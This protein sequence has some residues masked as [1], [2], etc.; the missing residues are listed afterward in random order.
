MLLL[1]NTLFGAVESLWHFNIKVLGQTRLDGL[2]RD[3]G[4]RV[5]KLTCGEPWS[6]RAHMLNYCLIN[7]ISGFPRLKSLHIHHDVTNA[8]MQTFPHTVCHLSLSECYFDDHGLQ[9]LPRANLQSLS[10]C[11]CPNVTDAGL[12]HFENLCHLR[13]NY[14]DQVQALFLPP[15]LKSVFLHACPRVMTIPAL[16]ELRTL[17]VQYCH[18]FQGSAVTFLPNLR[19][20]QVR[21]CQLVQDTPRI[22]QEHL[23]RGRVLVDKFHPRSRHQLRYASYRFHV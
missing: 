12:S 5:L 10:L 2:A 17:S 1:V 7:D 14:I 3:Y 19:V 22:A 16:P 21:H 20:L 11:E 8:V 23:E 4:Q 13:L 18:R 6:E 9:S 15:K